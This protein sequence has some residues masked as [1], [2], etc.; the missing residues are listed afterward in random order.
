MEP[1]VNETSSSVM[2]AWIVLLPLAIVGLFV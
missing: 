2:R 1:V